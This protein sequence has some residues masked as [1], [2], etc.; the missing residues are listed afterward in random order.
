MLIS[1]LPLVDIA[2]EPVAGLVALG[3]DVGDVDGA[4][5]VS[6]GL[7]G[8]ASR[9]GGRLHGLLCGVFAGLGPGSGAGE[10]IR[11]SLALRAVLPD[12]GGGVAGMVRTVGS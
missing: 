8:R 5:A 4:V 6:P 12:A 3:A 7:S 11:P 2:A 10:A 1:F 9:A